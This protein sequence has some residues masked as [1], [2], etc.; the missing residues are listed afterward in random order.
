MPA[1]SGGP[2]EGELRTLTQLVMD[3]CEVGPFLSCVY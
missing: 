1:V 2:D 3:I